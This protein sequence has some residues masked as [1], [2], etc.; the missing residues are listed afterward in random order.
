MKTM[1][2]MATQTQV[3]ARSDTKCGA[4]MGALCARGSGFWNR[5]ME[6]RSKGPIGTRDRALFR[7]GSRMTLVALV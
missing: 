1:Q 5:L 4:A 3:M 7:V 2:Q 6:R